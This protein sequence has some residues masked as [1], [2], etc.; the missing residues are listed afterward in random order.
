MNIEKVSLPQTPE[1]S[2]YRLLAPTSCF[3]A[4]RTQAHAEQKTLASFIRD[5]LN[6]KCGIN[7]DGETLAIPVTGMEGK[8][9]K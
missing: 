5:T 6:A 7:S 4:W 2:A 1:I 9:T 3:E 8:E